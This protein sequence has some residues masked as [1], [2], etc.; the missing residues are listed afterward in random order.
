MR[1]KID[2]YATV[3]I[4]FSLIT[5]ISFWASSEFF[6]ETII[7][8]L[9]IPFALSAF[10]L[11]TALLKHNH[12][13]WTLNF[14]QKYI[15]KALIVTLTIFSSLIVLFVPAYNGSILALA[16][17]PLINWMRYLL[18]LFLTMFLPG[19]YLLKIIDSR[20]SIELSATIPFSY[21]LSMFI[22][23]TLGFSLLVTYGSI[24]PLANYILVI[25]NIVLMII[26]YCRHFSQKYI[27]IDTSPVELGAICA[28]LLITMVGGIYVMNNTLPLSR[29]DMWRHNA[30]ALQYSKGFPMYE[31]VLIPAYPYF[32]HIFLA[33][34][35]Q[36]SG[37]PSQI[38]YQALFILSFIPVLSFF[39]F[40][41]KWF[42]N[43][44][45]SSIAILLIP[46]LGFGSLYAINLKTQNPSI[47]LS[48]VLSETMRKTYDISDVMIIGPTLSNVVPILYVAL[49]TFFMFLY[50]L[51]KDLNSAAKLLL[52]ALLVAVSFL[53]HADVSFFMALSLLL[54]V[55]TLKEGVKEGALG[56]IFGLLIV[57]L[58]DAFAPVRNY[59]WSMG[60]FS[61]STITFFVTLLLFV[62]SYVTSL[63]VSRF[64]ILCKVGSDNLRRAFFLIPWII[65]Y[66]YL[67]SLTVWLYILPTYD[68][69][70][71]GHYEFTPFFVWPTRFGPVGLLFLLYV[72]FSLKEV[73]KD[74]RLTFFLALV[75]TGFALEQF[76]NYYPLYPSYRF[77]TLT[78][79]GA[80]VLVAYGV[81]KSSRLWDKKKALL[82]TSILIIIIIPGMSSSS[83][84]YYQRAKLA[85]N[86]NDSELDALRF[87]GKNLLSNSSVLTFTTDSAEKL[88]TFGGINTIQIM[89]RWDYILLNAKDPA[90]FFYVLGMSNAKYLYL[91]QADY[92]KFAQNSIINA[93]I[94]DLPIVLKNDAV[95]IYELPKLTPP[96]PDACFLTLD[97]FNSSQVSNMTATKI[98]LESLPSRL[99]LN[100][101]FSM[102]PLSS[103]EE[104][105]SLKLLD[106]MEDT[107]GI[108]IP[109]GAGTL[110]IDSDHIQGNASVGVY[111]LK[112]NEYGGFVIQKS[113]IW[114]LAN[115]QFL[116]FWV[117][118]PEND[119]KWVKVTLRSGAQWATWRFREV[120]PS[121]KWVELLIQL[122]RP[123][124]ISEAPLNL[125]KVDRVE[126]G[127]NGASDTL[128]DYFK[129]DFITT[130]NSTYHTYL[131]TKLTRILDGAEVIM[132]PYDPNWAADGLAQWAEKGGT[133][134]ILNN[135]SV[136]GFFGQYLSLTK[137][138]E[139]MMT[140]EITFENGKRVQIPSSQI[141][142]IS[143]TENGTSVLASYKDLKN[144]TSPFLLYKRV[145]NGS[146]LYVR[147][148][149][150]QPSD[151]V[152]PLLNLFKEIL[153]VSKLTV[154]QSDFEWKYFPVYRTLEEKTIIDGSIIIHTNHAIAAPMNVSNVEIKTDE[155]TVRYGNSTIRLESVKN[156]VLVLNGSFEISSDLATSYLIIS[157]NL[158]QNSSIEV[159]N[160]VLELAVLNQNKTYLLEDG[161]ITFETS[162]LT[163][164][165]R[166]PFCE[167]V[168]KISFESARIPTRLD[169]PSYRPLAG[170]VRSEMRVDGKVGLKVLYATKNLILVSDFDYV[171]IV[172]GVGSQV[173]K[174][175]IPWIE[176]LL[177]PLNVFVI[178]LVAIGAYINAKYKIVI[179]LEKKNFSNVNKSN[180]T[181]NFMTEELQ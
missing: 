154:Q 31:G 92:N 132:L 175:E 173:E 20:S 15:P 9:G 75:A 81:A 130:F 32:F 102:F 66:T 110:V 42:P 96:S 99:D 166:E 79:I 146:I 72:G 71:F 91:S 17:I 49:P 22:V 131:D 137:S 181:K 7:L 85:P 18:S 159:K 118:V 148:P 133:L 144:K 70:K 10:I 139:H 44:R 30:L 170:V 50:L 126:V 167:F 101:S 136:V 40:I 157:G 46:L 150:L 41:K 90:I 129:V 21:I 43:K 114:D 67:F 134:L 84:Y 142:E 135:E 127:F 120:P 36:L 14:P 100:Y 111:E 89:Q 149:T 12:K 37:V 47:T 172:K 74:K 60:G 158:S 180:H 116:A 61:F 160:G 48:N 5:L 51:R 165:I 138:D 155:T 38:S 2:I 143:L 1:L 156:S 87:V 161:T 57:L 29:G 121:N 106:G 59:V 141:S 77:A 28:T 112:T 25:V 83:L 115:Y 73:V 58:V 163:V 63:L 168:G 151:R 152:Q 94:T 125:S 169:P 98:L 179:K 107:N 33:T 93:F 153:D 162:N 54:Y 88:E 103:R 52:F 55:I 123:E 11:S 108:S 97:F 23:F 34:F 174:L 68:V 4:A 39:S 6:N 56:G 16:S 145:G 8:Y 76:A 35:F 122:D 128:Y 3:S 140:N 105:Y 19:Y 171:G 124:S 64:H 109:E 113:V 27:T 82:L 95:T 104:R 86:I 13:K 78:F 53:G 178:L 69:I 62:L 26:Y 24:H 45:V 117:Q 164:I 176:I 177:S 119:L 80:V 147:L 65:L